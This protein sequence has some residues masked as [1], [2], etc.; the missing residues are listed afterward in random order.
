MKNLLSEMHQPFASY[1][2]LLV[3][4][5]AVSSARAAEPNVVSCPSIAG[6]EFVAIPAGDFKM[7]AQHGFFRDERP[8]TTIHMRSFC[9]AKRQLHPKDVAG[10]ISVLGDIVLGL[11]LSEVGAVEAVLQADGFEVPVRRG[12]SDLAAALR[13]FQKA[14]K[15]PATGLVDAATRTALEKVKGRRLSKLSKEADVT[16]IEARALADALT[17]ASGRKVRLPT[18]AEWERAARGSLEGM[19]TPWGG[20]N[21]RVNG[22]LISDIIDEG[23]LHCRDFNSSEAKPHRVPQNSF[24]VG[25]LL[26]N[27]EWTNTLY[28]PYPYVATD[29]RES[30]DSSKGA[31]SVRGNGGGAESCKVS[32]SLRGYSDV[33]SRYS[34]RLA[35]Q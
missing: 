10:L 21:Q 17:R 26:T 6:I 35:V 12:K 29:G 34:L 4:I 32:V 22:R 14:S 27:W 7:G 9:I 28:A 19:P 20:L 5:L 2:C 13:N 1:A 23:L 15:L 16:W 11:D 8:V 33:S 31:R 30:P 25:D 24:G 3:S 18:E